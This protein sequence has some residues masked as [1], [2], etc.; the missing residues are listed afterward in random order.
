MPRPT[1]ES[2][3]KAITEWLADF[4]KGRATP[5]ML[6]QSVSDLWSEAWDADEA[7]RERLKDAAYVA[8]DYGRHH[9]WCVALARVGATCDCG[10][11]EA[12]AALD[13]PIV[14]VEEEPTCAA[15][16]HPLSVH[17]T[18][19]CL[20]LVGAKDESRVESC[21]CR[22]QISA[23]YPEQ[24]AADIE[25]WTAV[26]DE[27]VERYNREQRVRREAYE[28]GAREHDK[29]RPVLVRGEHFAV[30]LRTVRADA[31][32]RYPLRKRVPKVILDPHKDGEWQAGVQPGYSLR[33]RTC[34]PYMWASPPSSVLFT[35]ERMLALAALVKNPWTYEE[36]TE[37]ES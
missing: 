5:G 25:G 28:E 19:G 23:A 17:G 33:W 4:D 36:S 9:S 30:W 18:F 13:V 24:R 21:G 7:E 12:L 15:C 8:R 20:E 29:M 14:A 16:R 6:A 37:V 31:A 34:P 22:A 3:Q 27:Q 35:P 26:E 11:A 1:P 32:R 2:R 10:F